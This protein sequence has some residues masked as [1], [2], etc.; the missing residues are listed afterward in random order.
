MMSS[1]LSHPISMGM[2]ELE[3]PLQ[4][5]IPDTQA[6]HHAHPNSVS[7]ET[8]MTERELVHA[9]RNGDEAA[10]SLLM[11]RYHTRLIWVARTFVPSQAVAEEVVQETW[12]AVLEGID[13]FEGRS[14]LKTWIFRILTNRAKS[15]GQR[16]HRYVSFSDVSS[17]FDQEED[18]AMEPERFHSTGPL[19]GHWAS[20]P[21]MIPA[22][23][24]AFSLLMDRYHTRLIRVARTF[25]P[26][27]AVAEEVVQETWL[28]VLEG[29]DRFEGRSSL[30]TWIF[31]I[32]TNRAKSKG[33]REHRY[34]SFSDVSSP[35]DQEEDLAMEPE[36][37]HTTGP[38]KGHWDI[39]PT[40]WEENTPERVLLS[41]E[42]LAHLEKAI[43]A[44]PTIQRQIILLRDIEGIDS[45]EVCKLFHVTPTNQRVLLHRARSKVRR[46]LNQYLQG[47]SPMP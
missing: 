9:L 1:A 47:L 43:Q 33:Q 36:R 7:S 18:L 29:I 13:R 16:E 45:E 3:N 15:K 23:E 25:V 17:P 4:E 34:V 8:E 10:F 2:Y 44:L 26:S 19:K 11:D 20:S 38:L 21:S 24:A 14:S 41:K 32:L 30:K 28:A 22:H 12:L 46:V 27:Q 6:P 31:R 40:T 39:S 37:F 35:F 5:F 42:G